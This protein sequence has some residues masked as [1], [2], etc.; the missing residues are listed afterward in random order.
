[1]GEVSFPI[2]MMTTLAIYDFTYIPL[3]LYLTDIRKPNRPPHGKENIFVTS[4]NFPLNVH[5]SR[6][7]FS[8]LLA[9]I[10]LPLYWLLLFN[11][12]RA[13]NSHAL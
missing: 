6:S 1:M 9:L 4:F 3:L 12:V 11:Y 5:Q 10:F 2:L 8:V 7:L 13:Q